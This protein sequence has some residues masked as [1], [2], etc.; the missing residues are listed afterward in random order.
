MTCN[1]PAEVLSQVET[2]R[3][4]EPVVSFK[5]IS[6]WLKDDQGIE[7]LPATLRNHFIAGHDHD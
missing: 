3:T 1:L 4:Q 7:I 6:R 5:I 2:A